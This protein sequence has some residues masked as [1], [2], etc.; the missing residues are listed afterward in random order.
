MPPSSSSLQ[1]R[2]RSALA[3]YRAQLPQDLTQDEIRQRLAKRLRSLA[4]ADQASL[5]R[6]TAKELHGI[7][8]DYLNSLQRFHTAQQTRHLAKVR[9]GLA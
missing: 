5:H 1:E 9:S 2:Y 8:K 4:A 7:E 3:E 6:Q